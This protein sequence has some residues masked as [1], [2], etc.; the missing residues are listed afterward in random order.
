MS[1]I[2]NGQKKACWYELNIDVTDCFKDDYEFPT[3]RG[4][5]EIWHVQAGDIFKI[6]WLKHVNS[7][8]LPIDSALIFYRSPYFSA[9]EAHIDIRRTDPLVLSNFGINWCRGGKDSQMS[10]YDMPENDNTPLFYTPANTAYKIWERSQ[11]NFIE[12][13]SIGERATLVRT[14][15]PHSIEMGSEPR[16]SISARVDIYDE[17]DWDTMVDL[18]R[19]QDLLIERSV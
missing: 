11:L 16:W 7:L 3:P 8:G 17:C 18:M 15:I 6:Q 2:L 9:K 13:K 5:S 12:S 10:W 4:P 1:N 19:K 14:G